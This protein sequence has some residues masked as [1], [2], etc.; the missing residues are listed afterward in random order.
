MCEITRMRMRAKNIGNQV[1]I[2][3]QHR[4]IVLNVI[5]SFVLLE[6]ATVC[7]SQTFYQTDLC[8]VAVVIGG[9]VVR[10][11]LPVRVGQKL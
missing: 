1:L 6:V 10:F 11:V 4:I 7:S 8:L 9:I 2:L 3:M 5:A